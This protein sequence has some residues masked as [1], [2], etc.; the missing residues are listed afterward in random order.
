MLTI[1]GSQGEGGGQMLRSS[2]A[3][4]M[5]TST[6][7]RLENIRAN[8][9]KPGLA[10]QHLTCVNAAAEVCGADVDGAAMGSVELTFRP[11]NVVSGDFSFQIGTAGSTTLVLQTVLPAL[12]CADGPS[13]VSV[14]G[15][16]HNPMAPTVEFLQRA[17]LPLLGRMGP[18]VDVRLKRYGFYPAGGGRIMASIAPI[19][20]LR[21][22][23][24][25]ER[26]K[27]IERKVRSLI[28]RLPRH[29]GERECSKVLRSLQWPEDCAEIVATED[30]A[31]PG[32][33][34]SVELRYQ[35]VTEIFTSFGE[36]RKSAE[37]VARDVLPEVRRYR[38]S[39]APVGEHLADQLMLPMAIGAWQGTG[40]GTYR[41]LDLSLHSR[42]HL[43]VIHKF[44]A[45]ETDIVDF[46]ND[47]VEVRIHPTST[48][49][50]TS[51]PANSG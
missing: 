6:P 8:R 14:E 44:L 9:K 18:T 4:A 46:G 24:L 50:T 48:V 17:Y 28:A 31:S 19:Q 36:R 16:T 35:N 43:D 30:A 51:V 2:L 34:A 10:R 7:V 22:L 23:E 13:S 49:P 39:E 47:M 25:L 38:K 1:D 26:G 3:L 40:G 20:S 15:G 11:G 21:R 41:T 37:H 33:T 12:L 29:V 42:T 45:I 5:V 27:L 32:N